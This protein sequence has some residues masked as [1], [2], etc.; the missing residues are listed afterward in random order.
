MSAAKSKPAKRGLGRGFESLL[1]PDF[2][3]SI[4]MDASERIQN[5][6]LEL[7][8]PNADQPR[9]HFDE[10]A[11][12]QLA[13]SI[14]RYGVLQPLIARPQPS[15]EYQIIAGERRWRAAKLAGKKTLPVIV[16][17]A[18][19]LEQLEVSLVENMQRVDLSL[20]EQAASIARLNQQFSMNYD[21]IGKRL[22]KAGSTVSNIMR[23]LNLPEKAS[24]ALDEHKISEGHARAILALKDT[25]AKQAELLSL[26]I[27]R[28]WS[29]RQA[30]RFVIALKQG[31]PDVTSRAV[32]AK[33]SN[34]TP[35][36]RSLSKR[37]GA[38]VTVRRTAHGGKLEIGF[39][40]DNELDK[41]IKSLNR[42][43]KSL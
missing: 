1:P 42:L 26:I 41:L 34:Q 5:I 14:N 19:Q 25:P 36:T 35:Q 12:R 17:S 38:P 33:V 28:G 2:D 23:L 40:S 16:R 7:L 20:L 18:E 29:V 27:S 4:L 8:E 21:D 32:R 3:P 10:N 43:P 9:R 15:G 39:T 31:E 24:L 22:G 30:E 11:L 37:I 6:K 13:D